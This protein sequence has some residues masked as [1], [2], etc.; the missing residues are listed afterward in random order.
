[1]KKLMKITI[2]ALLILGT[3]LS[4]AMPVFAAECEH[5]YKSTYR[6][7]S[8]ISDG[9]LRT[10]CTK[11][12]HLYS[13]VTFKAKE[14]D[15]EMSELDI[16]LRGSIDRVCKN[17]NDTEIIPYSTIQEIYLKYN[18]PITLNRNDYLF[19]K[20][21]ELFSLELISSEEYIW[22]FL[23]K[24]IGNEYGAAALMGNLYAESALRTNNLEQLY[25][26]EYGYNDKSYTEEVDA[27]TYTNFVD[28][29]A[30]YGLA[31]W[32]FYVRK[33]NLLDYSKKTSRSIADLNMQLEFLMIELR[34]NYTGVMGALVDAE[35]ILDASN[36][37]LHHFENPADQ[38]EA[39]QETRAS[40]GQKYY[41][42]YHSVG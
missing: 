13:D 37:V 30:G 26:M 35:N 6:E 2:S 5:D 31:Q 7:A 14:H 42:R 4:M 1:M 38:S 8:C 36:Y 22:R 28:D 3:L 29:H 23:V 34:E 9:H 12:G 39:V 10:E 27:G 19:L 40:F 16:L 21:S 32:T 33:Q 41:D 15:F 25:E 24:E 11:C 18:L 17:C 20:R